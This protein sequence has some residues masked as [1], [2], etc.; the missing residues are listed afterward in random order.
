MSPIDYLRTVFPEMFYIEKI[1]E[2]PFSYRMYMVTATG[3]GSAIYLFRFMSMGWMYEARL[4]GEYFHW[5]KWFRRYKMPKRVKSK[6]NIEGV[7]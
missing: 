5:M 3:L 4:D 7:W 1:A 2:S 6:H